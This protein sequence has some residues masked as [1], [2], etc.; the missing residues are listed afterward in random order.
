MIDIS[1]IR[2]VVKNTTGMIYMCAEDVVSMLREF[3]ATE[4]TD[5]RSRINELANGI[6]VKKNS[7]NE[8]FGIRDF[9]DES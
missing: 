2:C 6:P 7:K 9:P 3:G 5:I 4:E 1:N 8:L